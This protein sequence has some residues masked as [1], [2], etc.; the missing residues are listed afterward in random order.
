MHI[1]IH[2]HA[3]EQGEQQND[4]SLQGKVRNKR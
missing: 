1:I 2:M 3:S 4:A